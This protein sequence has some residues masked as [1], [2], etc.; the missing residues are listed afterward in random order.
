MRLSAEKSVLNPVPKPTPKVVSKILNR[1]TAAKLDRQAKEAV[2]KRDQECCRIC[3]RKSREVHERI[4]K[5]RGGEAS[6]ENSLVLCRLCHEL[7]QHHGVRIYGGSCQGLLQ[8]GM[9]EQ[10][11]LLIFEHKARPTHVVIER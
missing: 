4:F 8:F 6:L 7:T 11:A 3:G 9:S 10:A 5:S 2:R 1:R